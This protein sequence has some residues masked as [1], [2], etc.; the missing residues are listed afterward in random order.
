MPLPGGCIMGHRHVFTTL[1]MRP[2][3]YIAEDYDFILRCIEQY[4]ISH[5]PNVLYRCR[6]AD[7]QHKTLSTDS[8]K[9]FDLWRY[10]L[11]AWISAYCRG[12][13]RPDPVE[14]H[15]DV[16]ALLRD[17]A[18]LFKAIPPAAQKHLLRTLC[19]RC[20]HHA[21][22]HNDAHR[23]QQTLDILSKLSDKK[24]ILAIMPKVLFAC[25]RRGR[26]SFIAPFM[27][28]LLDSKQP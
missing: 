11:A 2:F 28:T 25:L 1:E 16:S 13:S 15:T 3:F 4:G 19:R 23:Y 7:A 26:A 21:L 22:R 8:E 20:L 6:L 12:L 18:P 9:T 24:H 10:H 14:Q 5:I 27:T 17:T